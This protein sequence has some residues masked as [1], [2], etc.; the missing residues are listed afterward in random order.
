MY[1]ILMISVSTVFASHLALLVLFIQKLDILTFIGVDLL[2]YFNF[3]IQN[4]DFRVRILFCLQTEKS[5]ISREVLLNPAI[6]NNG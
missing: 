3:L 4:L 6:E 5:K 2:L 1:F